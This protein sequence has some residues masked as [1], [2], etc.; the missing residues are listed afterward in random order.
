MLQ[1]VQAEME[2]SNGSTPN[3]IRQDIARA[4]EATA[5]LIE[6]PPNYLS[7]ASQHIEFKA[8]VEKLQAQDMPITKDEWEKLQKKLKRKG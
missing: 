3:A 5:R 8:L 4:G 6:Y 7:E 2:N 1:E